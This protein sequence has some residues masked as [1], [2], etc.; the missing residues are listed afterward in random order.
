MGLTRTAARHA[1]DIL[2]PPT[3]H[4]FRFTTARSRT[5]AAVAFAPL[6]SACATDP[7]RPIVLSLAARSE[8]GGESSLAHRDAHACHR[9]RAEGFDGSRNG[10]SYDEC[11]ANPRAQSATDHVSVNGF[12]FSDLMALLGN[13]NDRGALFSFT[14]TAALETLNGSSS[15]GTDADIRFTN[16]R[17]HA[18]DIPQAQGPYVP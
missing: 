12:G 5:R 2:Q 9:P 7:M 18:A 10:G 3:F 14:S 6:A 13:N 1:S 11:P 15:V 8:S 17:F 4:G 16:R